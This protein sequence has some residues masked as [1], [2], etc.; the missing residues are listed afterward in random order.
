[1]KKPNEIRK[2]S[3]FLTDKKGFEK[4]SKALS[5]HNNIHIFIKN[6]KIN[7][8][9]YSFINICK[10]GNLIPEESLT[11][12]YNVFVDKNGINIKK[13]EDLK[14]KNLIENDMN[15]N[16][17]ILSKSKQNNIENKRKEKMPIQDMFSCD[18]INIQIDDRKV[19]TYRKTKNKILD[20]IKI[21]EKQ[22]IVGKKWGIKKNN[23]IK[24]KLKNN[25]NQINFPHL[26]YNHYEYD[27]D[28][29][30]TEEDKLIISNKKNIFQNP[31]EEFNDKLTF[32]VNPLNLNN[33]PKIIFKMPENNKYHQNIRYDKSDSSINKSQDEKITFNSNLNNNEKEKEKEKDNFNNK[34][35]MNQ[36]QSK[37]NNK[38]YK[39]DNSHKG[40]YDESS[41]NDKSEFTNNDQ[42]TRTRD[43][44]YFS[45]QFNDLD[46]NLK[47]Y[48][49]PFDNT[50]QNN[51]NDYPNYNE[52]VAIDFVE[53]DFSISDAK[54]NSSMNSIEKNYINK[55]GNKSTLDI[56]WEYSY[57][58]FLFFSFLNLGNFIFNSINIG[59]FT[60]FSLLS[61]ITICLDFLSVIEGIY[62]IKTLG[63]KQLNDTLVNQ[64]IISA[65]IGSLFNIIFVQYLM[66]YITQYYVL[67]NTFFFIIQ[68]SLVINELFCLFLNFKINYMSIEENFLLPLKTPLIGEYD[69]ENE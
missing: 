55:N 47:N 21:P 12:V 61:L 39:R 45:Y 65:C 57:Y 53:N 22:T 50:S 23:N 4:F 58:S 7:F 37:F 10:Q 41:H 18:D 6:I 44:D 52:E 29:L 30:K 9:L 69:I 8:P 17:N 49:N 25:K 20:D 3:T 16:I 13:K 40:N 19:N 27:N 56:I 59:F 24:D 33:D 14:N 68:V 42:R 5:L 64:F 46:N 11:F 1:M 48:D 36:L 60:F 35:L 34:F 2:E 32:N 26:N 63:N 43:D 62:Q 67:N 38:N 28:I 51:N 66:D 54:R 31:N 15:N